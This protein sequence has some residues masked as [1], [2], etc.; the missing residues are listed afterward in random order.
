MDSVSPFPP[1]KRRK[2]DHQP[3]RTL[4]GGHCNALLS[5]G[6]FRVEC[7]CIQGAFNLTSQ[8]DMSGSFCTLCDHPLSAHENAVIDAL[9]PQVPVDSAG[10]NQ[11]KRECEVTQVV[12]GLSLCSNEETVL[13]LA[14]LLDSERIVYV[15]ETFGTATL[16]PLLKEHYRNMDK[17]VLYIRSRGF[18]YRETAIVKSYSSFST[19]IREFYPAINAK[20]DLDSEAVIIVDENCWS[21]ESPWISRQLIRELYSKSSKLN[22]RFC[23]FGSL[24]TIVYGIKW[25]KIRYIPAVF[26]DRQCI[27]VDRMTRAV[28]PKICVHSTREDLECTL[29]NYS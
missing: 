1:R 10:G 24:R 5:A 26:N 28:L 11:V 7:P 2:T 13:E 8:W 18:V 14:K 27:T 9:P 29:E 25:D 17:D 15:S 22:M 23:V 16:A 4:A 12:G 21:D 20:K 19:L 3:S 6:Q